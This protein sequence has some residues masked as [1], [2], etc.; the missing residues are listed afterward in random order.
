MFPFTLYA[1]E[2]PHFTK[3][4]YAFRPTFLANKPTGLTWFAY[5]VVIK[6]P[7]NIAF[8]VYAMRDNIYGGLG[9]KIDQFPAIVP[10]ELTRKFVEERAMLLARGRFDDELRASQRAIIK[11]YADEI[12]V[13]LDG[14]CI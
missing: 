12:L 4:S 14:V 5:D 6:S 3:S 1:E 13:T 2:T 8:V 10:A 11:S 9:D 7:T